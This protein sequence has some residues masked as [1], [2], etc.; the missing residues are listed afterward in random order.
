M[1]PAH[2]EQICY[3]ATVARSPKWSDAELSVAVHESRS[4]R[5]VCER[6]GVRAGGG[7]YASLRRHIVRLGIDSDHLPRV[8]NGQVRARRSWTTDELR[9]AVR[10]SS[11]VAQVQ[12]RL[13]FVPS[14]GMHRFLVRRM[15]EL[16]LS[17][18]HFTGQ[19]WARG[20]HASWGFRP[21]P[22]DE[23]LVAHSTYSSSGRLRRRLIAAGLKPGHC[24]ICGLSSWLGSALPLALDHVNGDPSD[25]RLAN[26]RILCPNCHAQT[27]TWC[28]RNRG[29][30]TPMQ[31]EQV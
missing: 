12:R 10:A 3:T 5:E 22:L 29:R 28:G 4:L 8:V 14:G 30:R 23:I 18:E 16:G 21:T 9:E 7:T 6:L 2:I 27:P 11:S 15:D 13:G 19:A 17:T 31:R 25:N 1:T 20:T 26:L 24:E